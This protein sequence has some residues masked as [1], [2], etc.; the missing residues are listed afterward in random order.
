MS[1]EPAICI[2]VEE[3]SNSLETGG[4]TAAAVITP[5]VR[6]IGRLAEQQQ[7]SNRVTAVVSKL[8]AELAKVQ[9]TVASDGYRR[10]A[11]DAVKEA[12]R[13]RIGMLEAK[14]AATRR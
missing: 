9:R 7:T 11:P 8:E 3:A 1:K 10:R 6:V 2:C 14:I 12:D 13:R 5:H 4:E